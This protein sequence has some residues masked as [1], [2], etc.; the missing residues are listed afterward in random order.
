ME[1]NLE[2]FLQKPISIFNNK[3]VLKTTIYSCLILYLMLGIS[4]VISFISP[5]FF[6]EN[7]LI[8]NILKDSIYQ[9]LTISSLGYFISKYRFCYWSLLSFYGIVYLK[10]IWFVDRYLYSFSNYLNFADLGVTIITITMIIY[11]LYKNSKINN[12]T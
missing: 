5:E 11:F 1:V 10:V 12:L 9:I 2:K 7:I 4:N 6:K 8:Y 3:Y